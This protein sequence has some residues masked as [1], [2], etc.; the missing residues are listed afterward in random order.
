MPLFVCN[1][2]GTVDN[3][4]LTNYWPDVGGAEEGGPLPPCCSGCSPDRVLRRGAGTTGGWH[5]MFPRRHWREWLLEN[6]GNGRELL[7]LRPCFCGADALSHTLDDPKMPHR[8][9]GCAG[10]SPVPWRPEHARIIPT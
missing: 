4:A 7:N 2:C 1:D 3:T 9:T 6:P 8:G 10:Y 5:G